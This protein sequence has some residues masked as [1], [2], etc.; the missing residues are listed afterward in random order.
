MPTYDALAESLLDECGILDNVDAFD[1]AEC[2]GLTISQGKRTFLSPVHNHVC[3][4]THLR[5][6][7]QQFQLAH[8]IGHLVLRAH[9]IEDTEPCCNRFASSLLMPRRDFIA[10]MKRYG[11]QISWLKER[12]PRV[13][14]EAIGRRICA[15]RSSATLWIH[16][17]PPGGTLKRSRVGRCKMLLGDVLEAVEAASHVRDQFEADGVS[18]CVV[19]ES[20]WRR[21][22]AVG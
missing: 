14:H 9:G 21:V 20:G 3:L 22:F 1:V 11:W 16:D 18:V 19:V 4:P 17:Y 10:A 5:P 13:S 6:E 2:L 8:E 12:F 7:R 15:L